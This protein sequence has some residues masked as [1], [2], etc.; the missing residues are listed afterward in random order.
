[1]SNLQP[2]IRKH[3]ISKIVLTFIPEAEYE[4]IVNFKLIGPTSDLNT[5]V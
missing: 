5:G 1:M 3:V 2:K 4:G